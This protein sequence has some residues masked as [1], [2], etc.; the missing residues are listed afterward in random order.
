MPRGLVGLGNINTEGALMPYLSGGFV[1]QGALPQQG[2]GSIMPPPGGANSLAPAVDASKLG[3]PGQGGAATT[4]VAQAQVPGAQAAAGMPPAPAPGGPPPDPG[5]LQPPTAPP[6]PQP[7]FVP[8]SRGEQLYPMGK[9]PVT[10]MV[11][12]DP[13]LITPPM[14]QGAAGAPVGS[15]GAAGL[16]TLQAAAYGTHSRPQGVSGRLSSRFAAHLKK[17]GWCRRED[18]QTSK[19]LVALAV[20]KSSRVT[21]GPCRAFLG[22]ETTSGPEPR[23]KAAV[24][25]SHGVPLVS[26]DGPMRRSTAGEGDTSSLKLAPWQING[27][28]AFDSVKLK[29]PDAKGF[30]SFG[31]LSANLPPVARAFLN[32]CVTK[33]GMNGEQVIEAAKMASLISEDIAKELEPL[34]KQ[35]WGGPVAAG[36]GAV[37]RWGKGLVGLGAKAGPKAMKAMSKVKNLATKSPKRTAGPPP[38][39]LPK[40]TPVSSKVTPALSGG[41]PPPLPKGR[42]PKVT[43]RPVAPPLPKISPP[44]LPGGGPPALP[45]GPGLLSKAKNLAT[46]AIT[47]PKR[48]GVRGAAGSPVGRTA[49]GYGG[50]QAAARGSNAA[51]GTDIDPNTA[52]LLG[53]GVGG[54]SSPMIRGLN[55]AYT[56]SLGGQMLRKTPVVGKTLRQLKHPA[57]RGLFGAAAGGGAGGAV[58]IGEGVLTGDWDLDKAQLGGSI[59]G[60]LGVGGGVARMPA[61][62]KV[63]DRLG[64]GGVAR[65][66]SRATKPVWG[67]PDK[68]PVLRHLLGGGG[69]QGGTQ[70][71]GRLG[72]ATKALSAGKK[73]LTGL[74]LGVGAAEA[75]QGMLESRDNAMFDRLNYAFGDEPLIDGVGEN[76]VPILNPKGAEMALAAQTP[77]VQAEFA[78]MGAKNPAAMQ[79][80]NY[81]FGGEPLIATNE[82]GEMMRTEDG[83]PIFNPPGVMAALEAQPPEV[84]KVF[85]D[86]AAKK[87][88]VA[89]GAGG[90]LSGVWEMI[91]SNPVVFGLIAGGLITLLLGAM[92]RSP[93]LAGAGAL[94]AGAGLLGPKVAPGLFGQS[95]ATSPGAA[96]LDG[97]GD[98]PDSESFV[99]EPGAKPAEPLISRTRQPEMTELERAS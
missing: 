67:G 44:P 24:T 62:R 96:N 31:K 2:S 84:Q 5:Q 56:R 15:T 20:E 77:E 50:G 59:G 36:A 53:A 37:A 42:F 49:V 79:K 61:L 51:F 14:P 27:P 9:G 65:G 1:P 82:A 55:P 11:P 69:R 45:Q 41:G 48:T 29:H 98:L 26:T 85:M 46:R 35:A 30:T 86:A 71:P 60:G 23:K 64:L 97:G 16:L 72:A 38:M 39:P 58:D 95:D 68:V 80:L 66:V 32:R 93:M 25:G 43:P 70:L 89:G 8:N 81:A 6:P 4:E 83:A 21:Q 18:R 92:T 57:G 90:M 17:L 73:N 47:T 34:A 22:I 99:P 52:G 13:S 54:L 33:H 40:V 88:G 3:G 91:K 94:A 63:I 19:S 75:G 28:A 87:M 74:G 76:G 12:P 10:E 7:G 78:A